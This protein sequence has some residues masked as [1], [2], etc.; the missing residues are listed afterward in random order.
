MIMKVILLFLM[1]FPPILLPII[2]LANSGTSKLPAAAICR[3]FFAGFGGGLIFTVFWGVFGWF[4][5]YRMPQKEMVDYDA[6]VSEL[7]DPAEL[8]SFYESLLLLW[9]LDPNS[10]IDEIIAE[11]KTLL[12][13]NEAYD[14]GIKALE[15]YVL[16]KKRRTGKSKNAKTLEDGTMTW[17][18]G[19]AEFS[20]ELIW[21]TLEFRIRII[22]LIGNYTPCQESKTRF[23]LMRAFCLE[24]LRVKK[25]LDDFRSKGWAAYIGK[26]YTF[27]TEK[28]SVLYNYLQAVPGATSL[29]EE[30]ESCSPTTTRVDWRKYLES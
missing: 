21:K 3:R 5:E 7:F 13:L 28:E 20:M 25:H 9:E 29:L 14:D 1:G 17:L 16:W 18:E 15:R 11:D 27:E 22:L 12:D 23:L 19:R 30:L 8:L 10:A 6:G 24:Y 26:E 4:L 2:L